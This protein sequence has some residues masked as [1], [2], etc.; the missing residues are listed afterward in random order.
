VVE[1]A[2]Q[3]R[4]KNLSVHPV[5]PDRWEDL[6]ALFERPGVRGGKSWASGC[7]CMWWR[8]P[9]SEFN[10][11]WGQDEERGAGNRS[12]LRS[13][14]DQRRVPGLLAYA[15]GVPAGWVSVGPRGEFPELIRSKALAPAE[16]TPASHVP[17]WSIVCFYIHGSF[18]RSGVGKALLRAAVEYAAQ[19]GAASV[20]GY[21]AQ[22]GA[23]DSF[24]GLES[25]FLDAGFTPVRKMGKTIIVRYDIDKS[26]LPM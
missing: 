14:V 2:E 13:I 5:T 4:L 8:L 1:Q 10:R 22:P 23:F 25:M 3:L 11:G 19:N 24:T 9:R 20:E 12:A 7:W 15:D 26:A 16:E 21:A 6:A 17:I 18:R